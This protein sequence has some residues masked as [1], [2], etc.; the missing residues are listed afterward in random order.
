MNN[1]YLCSPEYVN[2]NIIKDQFIQDLKYKEIVYAEYEADRLNGK[3]MNLQLNV[4]SENFDFFDII[5]RFNYHYGVINNLIISSSMWTYGIKLLDGN[6]N[7]HTVTIESFHEYPGKMDIENVVLIGVGSGNKI[8]DDRNTFAEEM[9]YFV[10]NKVIYYSESFF[11][12]NIFPVDKKE[13][14]RVVGEYKELERK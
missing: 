14:R 8:K 3:E 2:P 6:L 7:E 9:L 12:I 10:K 11:R 5:E 1:L 13:I 4:V